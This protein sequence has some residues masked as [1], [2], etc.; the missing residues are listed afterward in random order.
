MAAG[1]WC[2]VVFTIKHPYSLII[3]M[4]KI[5]ILA[6]AAVGAVTL[7]VTGAQAATPV[8]ALPAV[9][10]INETVVVVNRHHH[11]RY[12]HHRRWYYR[13]HHRYYY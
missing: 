13:H 11:H 10:H 4:N 7:G 1:S 12:Y 6:C 5:L 8:N 2:T 3:L 9:A